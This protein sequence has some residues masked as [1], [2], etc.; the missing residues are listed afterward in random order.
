MLDQDRIPVVEASYELGKGN[1]FIMSAS[2]VFIPSS[3]T[4]SFPYSLP[5]SVTRSLPHSLTH[6]LTLSLPS[7]LP[8]LLDLSLTLTL[9]FPYSVFLAHSLDV[10]AY[11]Y[12]LPCITHVHDK[13]G[14]NIANA[15]QHNSLTPETTLFFPKKIELTQVGFERTHDTPFSRRVLFH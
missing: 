5:P 11:T 6:S 7:S 3:L 1:N 9:S 14:D 12:T 8:P 2:N 15:K 13:Q 4:P 10:H